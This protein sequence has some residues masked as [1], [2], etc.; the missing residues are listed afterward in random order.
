MRAAGGIVQGT[1][2]WGVPSLS[3][4]CAARSVRTISVSISAIC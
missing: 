4:F 2:D 3:P 1:D